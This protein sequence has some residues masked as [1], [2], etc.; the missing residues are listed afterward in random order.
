[1]TNDAPAHPGLPP[2]TGDAAR[3]LGAE[4]RG[5]GDLPL[6]RLDVMDQAEDGAL[7]FIRSAAFA[8]HWPACR[9]TAAIVTRGVDVPHHP[10]P[11][12]ALL[13]VDHADR[14][15]F[16]LLTTVSEG[17]N[18]PLFDHGVHST[19]FIHP[20]A[21]VDPS[22]TVGPFCAIGAHAAVGPGVLLEAHVSVGARCSVGARTRIHEGVVLRPLT[23]V[24]EDCLLHP[25]SVLGAD[26]FGFDRDENNIPVFIPHIAGVRVGDRVVIGG[27]CSI[28]RGK[29]SDTIIGDDVK[30]DNLTQ[31]GH[32]TRV[33]KATV[34]CGCC[35]LGG[36]CRIG[37]FVTIGGGVHMPDNVDVADHAVI[38]GGAF[39][40]GSV[41]AKE[42]WMGHPARPRSMWLRE[43]RAVKTVARLR[44]DLKETVKIVQRLAGRVGDID[45]KT[46]ESTPDDGSPA[47]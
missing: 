1:M 39:L 8:E 31:I 10:D 33:G 46:D 2:T 11:R 40:A 28:D 24:G 19:A 20:T 37:S 47:S 42:P 23:S 41:A 5:P 21:T 45:G 27:N 18:A 22:A 44:K 43:L 29:F 32:A 25:G 35:A 16:T 15:I 26:G 6:R 34:I 36:S 12:R 14:A 7:T 17:I 38:A 30:I 9:A 4:L 3:A 13:V